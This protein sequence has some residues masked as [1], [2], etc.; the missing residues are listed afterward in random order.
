[1]AELREIFEHYDKDKSGSI[2]SSELTTLLNAL[3][4]GMSE[5]EI[6]TGLRA[7]DEDGNG[8]IEFDEFVAWWTNR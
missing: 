8:T 6:A 5:A 7:L 1:M 3:D 4:A 2:E